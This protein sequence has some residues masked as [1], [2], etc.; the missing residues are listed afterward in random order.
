[1]A[2]AW[3]D[4]NPDVLNHPEQGFSV[5][6]VDFSE[7]AATRYKNGVLGWLQPS[8]GMDA[9][10]KAVAQIAFSLTKPGE[11]SAVTTTP[12][13]IFLVRC[14]AITPAF[15]RPFEEVASHLAAAERALNR[16]AAEEN[17][18]NHLRQK[19]SLDFESPADSAHR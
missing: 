13:G 18:E 12:E 2:R 7:H 8:G 9:W 11:V 19:Y 14:M 10:S 5:L 1:Q 15:E 17:F 16:Q 3:L 4:S 6:S